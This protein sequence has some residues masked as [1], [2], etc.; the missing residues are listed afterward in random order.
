MALQSFLNLEAQG[1][2]QR[3]T[4]LKVQIM[5]SLKFWVAFCRHLS[6]SLMKS[7]HMTTQSWDVD[8]D[9]SLEALYVCHFSPKKWWRG[10]HF[11]RLTTAFGVDMRRFRCVSEPHFC[12]PRLRFVYLL[13]LM[14][15]QRAAAEIVFR[16]IFLLLDV[17]CFCSRSIFSW[18]RIIAR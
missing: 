14:S 1:L 12:L 13:R 3:S 5:R 4:L 9:N 16:S 6:M 15:L 18:L 17:S 11:T 2:N 7:A 8:H 10:R